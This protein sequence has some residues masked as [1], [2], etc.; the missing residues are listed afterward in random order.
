VWGGVSK[1]GRILFF[2]LD[3][4]WHSEVAERL[5][6]DNVVGYSKFF[7]H[8]NALLCIIMRHHH[9]HHHHHQSLVAYGSPQ[10]HTPA[11][12]VRSPFTHYPAWRVTLARVANYTRNWTC[13]PASQLIKGTAYRN[14]NTGKSKLMT[15]SLCKY[16]GYCSRPWVNLTTI[17]HK[18]I[19]R[20]AS[21][22]RV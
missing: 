20:P 17:L 8:N 7:L 15:R 16:D 21:S 4:W 1:S 22:L 14:C 10:P 18:L 11:T 19:I 6:V 2:L 13:Q 9:H 3:V 12:R 5:V